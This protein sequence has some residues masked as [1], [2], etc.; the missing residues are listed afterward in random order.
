MFGQPYRPI[1]PGGDRTAR[2]N[3]ERGRA[4]R[5]RDLA[6]RRARQPA[7]RTTFG[8]GGS[9]TIYPWSMGGRLEARESAPHPALRATRTFTGVRIVLTEQ[10][11]TSTTGTVRVDGSDVATWIMPA[12]TSAWWSPFDAPVTMPAGSVPTAAIT[13]PGD[14]AEGITVELA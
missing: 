3:M 14:D 4:D 2:T 11:S 10:G 7:G 8:E 1:L 12:D 5:I 13:E 6:Q 9:Q